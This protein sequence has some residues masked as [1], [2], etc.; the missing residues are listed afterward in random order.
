MI[1]WA[2]TMTQFDY[3]QHYG[4]NLPHIQPPDA[5]LFVT[6]RLAGSIPQSV[7]DDWLQE[8]KRLK[9]A[10]KQRQAIS[11]RPDADADNYAK[12][13]LAFHRRWFRKFEAILHASGSGPIWLKDERLAAIVHNA[14]L[15]RDGKVFR[16]DASC[17]MPN[18]V[19]AVFAPLLNE[20]AA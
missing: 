4:R 3:K 15:H 16:L 2:T 7:L 17:I 1:A 13:R 20:P 19:H 8:K 18:H 11:R 9:S 12:E 5:T 14:L 6:F 10:E